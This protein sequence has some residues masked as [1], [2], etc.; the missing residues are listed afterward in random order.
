MKIYSLAHKAEVKVTCLFDN[1]GYGNGV[2]DW[3]AEYGYSMTAMPN[4][5]EGHGGIDLAQGL[6]TP[7]YAVTSGSA[8]VLYNNGT[9]G[10]EVRVRFGEYTIRYLHLDTISIA[11]GA[12]IKKGDRIGSEGGSGGYAPHLHFE[13]QKNGEKI[14]PYNIVQNGLTEITIKEEN[15]LMWDKGSKYLKKEAWVRHT[16]AW[17]DQNLVGFG[18]QNNY[19]NVVKVKPQWVEIILTE[20]NDFYLCEVQVDKHFRLAWLEKNAF[21]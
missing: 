8:Q 4:P 18:N 1:K 13:V 12:T 5:Y 15:Y 20:K 6:G 3:V 10:N 17:G 9:A 16:P 7:I 19:N 14:D 11:N 21:Q 2:R